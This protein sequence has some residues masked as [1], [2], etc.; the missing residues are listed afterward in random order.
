MDFHSHKYNVIEINYNVHDKILLASAFSFKQW[1][2]LLEGS[3]HHVIIYADHNNL[4]YFHSARV[5]HRR[6]DQV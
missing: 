4:T 5:L 6:Q 3:P 2:H 1:H